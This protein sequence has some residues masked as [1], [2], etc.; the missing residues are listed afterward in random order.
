MRLLDQKSN[1]KAHFRRRSFHEPNLI[2][3]IKY[4][5]SS[6]HETIKN[7]YLKLERLRRSFRLAWPGISALERL[8]NGFDSDAKPILMHK[9]FPALPKNAAN[10]KGSCWNFIKNG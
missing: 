2:P 8:W 5:K 7:G 6:A 1:S 9:L 10:M 4:M 3:W